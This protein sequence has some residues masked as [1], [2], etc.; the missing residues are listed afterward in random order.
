MHSGLEVFWFSFN[1]PPRLFDLCVSSRHKHY[2]SSTNSIE[3]TM[4]NYDQPRCIY[5]NRSILFR[6]RKAGYRL[7]PPATNAKRKHS[8]LACLS[9][10][11]LFGPIGAQHCS[12]LTKRRTL[13]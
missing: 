3:A 6:C 8:S 2:S 9:A 11:I 5:G 12:T 1:S 7:L 13:I 4:P 10:P